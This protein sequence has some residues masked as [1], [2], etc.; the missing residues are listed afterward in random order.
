MEDFAHLHVHSDMSLLTGCAT[1]REYATVAKERGHKGIAFTECGS[2]RGISDF[3]GVSKEL[4][5]KQIIGIE[6]YVCGNMR[7]KGLSQEDKARIVDDLPR[8]QWKR[9]I[10]EY[11]TQHG[12]QDRHTIT[13]WARTP[14]GM[15]NLFALTSHSWIYGF[16]YKPRIDVDEL[17]KFREGL[18]I[19]TSHHTSLIHAHALNGRRKRALEIADKL[20]EAFG[21]DMYVELLPHAIYKQSV[22]NKFSLSL[23]QRYENAQPLAT[24]D[25]HYLHEDD[26]KYQAMLAAFGEKDRPLDECGVEGK[27][28]WFKTRD[29]MRKSFRDKHSYIDSKIVEQSLDNTVAFVERIETTLAADRFQ[30]IIPD[31]YV[32][33]DCDGEFEYLSRL[34]IEGWEWRDIPARAEK[35]AQIHDIT[36]DEALGKYRERLLREL[37]ALKKQKFVTYILFVRELYEWAREQKI[38]CGPGRGSAAGSIV[39]YLVG[40]TSVDPIEHGLLFER[41]ISPARI[42]M[43]DIDMDFEDVRRKDI[44]E[45]LKLKYGELNTSQIATIGKLKGKACLRDISRVLK[46]PNAEVM[47]VTKAILERSSGDER[48]SMTIEDSFK[49]FAVC[50]DFNKRY[51]DVLRYAARIEGKS[52]TLGMH[53]AGVV[54][55]PVPLEQILP[56][57]TRLHEGERILVTA[58]DF[59]GTEG[60]GLLKL[61]VLGLRTM[62][63]LRMVR[64]EVC[65]RHGVDIDYESLP[66]DHE[67]VLQGFTDHNYTGIFQ[68]DSPGADKICSGVTFTHFEDI[69]AM[70]ALNRPGTA[71]SGLAGQYVARKK[72]PKLVAKASFHPAVS[73]ITSDTLGIIV[74]QEHVVK[75][76]TEVAGFEP[77]TA[78]SLRKKIAKKSGD[79]ALGKEREKFIEGA[80]AKTGMERDAAAKIMDAITFFGSY[81]FNKSH[82]TAYGMIAY[83]SMYAKV[84]YPLEFYKCLMYCE[85]KQDRVQNIAKDAKAHGIAILPPDVN[86]SG[87]G[88]AI[89]DKLNAI[90]GSLSDIKGV[91]TAASASIMENQPYVDFWDFIER[92][93]RRKVNKRVVL[94]L[95][96]AGALD[97]LLPNVKWFV[98]NVD[99]IWGL[100]EKKTK[101]PALKELL[102]KSSEL[103]DYTEEDKALLASKVSPLAFGKHPVDA[104]GDFIERAITV[105]IMPMGDDDFWEK[106][107]SSNIGG[108]WICGIIIE[109]RLNQVGDF[110]SGEQPSADEKARMGWG[111]QYANINVEGS[112]GKQRRV[113]FDWDVFEDYRSIIIDGGKGTVILAHVT[114]SAQWENLRAHVC[115]DLEDMRKREAAKA[116]Y[117]YW[118]KVVS[119]RHPSLLYPFKKDSLKK[120][121]WQNIDVIRA[122][123]KKRSKNGKVYFSVLGVVTH[124]REKLDRKNNLMGFFG[125][126]GIDG[127]I[128]CLC[129]ASNWGIIRRHIKAKSLIAVELEYNQGSGIFNNGQLTLLKRKKQTAKEVKKQ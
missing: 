42:D 1:M 13:I 16:Y 124:V 86:V 65:A 110:H 72:N 122:K 4:G 128:D 38:G 20:Y 105:P 76:F 52:K 96:L 77:G 59:W 2:L 75:I 106:A 95:A 116:P 82:A 117:D 80:M 34:C 118:Q 83:W 27:D 14:V 73:K 37:L 71:R 30:C 48:A 19:G 92:V 127:Y 90:R 21:Q 5:I 36:V 70:T 50:R 67:D 108:F 40:I 45:H 64:D 63:V 102:T 41:F 74:Y 87:V 100:K 24:Q 113:K 91:G 89:D 84:R 8:S 61:D 66:L 79:E 9:A 51:P 85:P 109:V 121:S 18:I 17:L 107:D 29:E 25:C 54:A 114:G 44:I 31:V 55:S 58:V 104:Y 10:T 78:D 93:D 22:A 11:E 7:R 126:L 39:N 125:V 98:D 123:A 97:S 129:F 46:V 103:E 56:L 49:E 99:L 28:H 94:S 68:Y 115:I 62:T 26:A 112:D 120:L 15:K 32:P 101:L 35:Y 43:P 3:I 12:I 23:L 33:E 111:K 81:G 47:P 88:F 53:A 119:G 57:E 6:A 60:F 69:A